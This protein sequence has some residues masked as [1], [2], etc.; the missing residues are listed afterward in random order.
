MF[1][2]A[3]ASNRVWRNDPRESS[4]SVLDICAARTGSHMVEFPFVYAIWRRSIRSDGFPD[5]VCSERERQ[6]PDVGLQHRY[7]AGF[8]YC[9]LLDNGECGM[10]LLAMVRRS[11]HPHLRLGL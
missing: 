1:N 4:A 2:G 8:E 10:R 11:L 7:W 3:R 6:L 9:R 5:G